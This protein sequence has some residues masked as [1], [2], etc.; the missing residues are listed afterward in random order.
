MRAEKADMQVKI[1]ET[2]KAREN[3]QKQIRAMQATL[4][5]LGLAGRDFE[6]Y[7]DQEIKEIKEI[8]EQRRIQI[9]QLKTEIQRKLK[10]MNE[11]EAKNEASIADKDREISVLQNDAKAS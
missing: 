3:D 10:K 2:E 4:G 7:R 8:S 11:I 9:E 5:T 1:E 6:G